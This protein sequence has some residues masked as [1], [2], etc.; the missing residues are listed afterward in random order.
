MCEVGEWRFSYLPSM[1]PDFPFGDSKQHTRDSNS[2]SGCL[3]LV[4]IEDLGN[5]RRMR[6]PRMRIQDFHLGGGGGQQISSSLYRWPE[7]NGTVEQSILGLCS[8]QQSFFHLA[9]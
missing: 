8:N 2:L 4:M 6:D 3:T 7:K 9:G 5:D 1:Q